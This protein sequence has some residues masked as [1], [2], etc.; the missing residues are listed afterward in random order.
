MP[1]FF[2]LGRNTQCPIHTLH[3]SNRY[4]LK[5]YVEMHAFG[6]SILFCNP[7]NDR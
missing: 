7:A 4:F 3:F 5:C 1:T 2:L 6:I